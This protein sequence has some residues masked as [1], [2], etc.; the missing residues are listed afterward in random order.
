M[1]SVVLSRK[2]WFD[3]LVF[4]CT[5]DTQKEKHTELLLSVLPA[6]FNRLKQN[7]MLS[8]CSKTVVLD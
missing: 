5:G 1:L 6:Q 4:L 2:M 3:V 7:L 8:Y